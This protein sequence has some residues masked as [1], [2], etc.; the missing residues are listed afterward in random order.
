MKN[1][2]LSG[3]VTGCAGL[4]SPG[5]RLCFAL[6]LAG[7]PIVTACSSRPSAAPS[8]QVPQPTAALQPSNAAVPSTA[9]SGNAPA[10]AGAQPA[11]GAR[12]EQTRTGQSPSASYVNFLEMFRDPPD[13]AA[14]ATPPGPRSASATPLDDGAAHGPRMTTAAAPPSAPADMPS[15]GVYPSVSLVDLF[16]SASASARTANVPHPPATYTP[17][18]EPYV[19]PA[20]QPGNPPARAAA[21][22]GAASAGEGSAAA[23]AP[24]SSDAASAMPYPQQSLVDVLFNRSA[25]Q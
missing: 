7:L 10:A 18:G 20:G 8:G 23:S 2:G 13:A 12:G 22:G 11:P 14:V 1:H 19:A 9:P 4:A 24:A 16:K 17:V 5:P 21:A 15:T 3:E 25:Q 6:V